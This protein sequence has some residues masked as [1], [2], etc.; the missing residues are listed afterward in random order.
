V[1]P[2]RALRPWAGQVEAAF[3]FASVPRHDPKNP[4]TPGATR[5]NGMKN[6][7]YTST[8]VFPNDFPAIMDGLPQPSPQQAS[9][10]ELLQ[11]TGVAGECRVMCFHPWSDITLPL[12]SVPDIVKVMDMWVQQMIELGPRFKW[13][14]IFENKGQAMGCSNPHPHCQ[15]WATGHLPTTAHRKDK[16]QKAYFERHGKPLLVDYAEIEINAKERIVVENEDWIAVVP[17]WAVWPYETLLMPRRRHILRITNLMAA[18]RESCASIMKRLL[19]KYDNLFKTSFPYSMGW[20]GAPT[21][22]T[23]DAE[24]QHW[25]LHA[26]YYPPLLRSASVKKFM[27][28]Y[29]MHAEPQRDLTAEQAAVKLRDLPEAHYFKASE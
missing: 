4:L 28:G 15:V 17:W 1:S 25:Q 27:V 16:A 20:H 14:Q 29:E 6:D 3:D 11:L 5:A 23:P 7:E 9:Q 22:G 21:G 8:Y 18:E 26:I 19:I 24:V 2:H 13:V 12:M 10:H